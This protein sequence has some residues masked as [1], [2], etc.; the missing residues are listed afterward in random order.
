M[1]DEVNQPLAASKGVVLH[2]VRW[3]KDT[4][5]SFG[6]DAQALINDQ[7]ARMKEYAILVGIM[8][9]RL[10]TPT[11][12]AQS[13]TVEEFERAAEAFRQSGH[14][15][16]W[17][18]FRNAPS[19]FDTQEQLDQREGVLEFRRRLGNDGLTFAYK[20]PGDFR[21]LFRQHLNKWLINGFPSHDRELAETRPQPES[22]VYGRIELD[23]NF[24]VVGGMEALE[25]SLDEIL[26]DLQER[27]SPRVTVRLAPY[28]DAMR[29]LSG[30]EENGIWTHENRTLARR[31]RSVRRRYS[32][33]WG[34]PIAQFFR[35]A[36]VVGLRNLALYPDNFFSVKDIAEILSSLFQGYYSVFSSR[37]IEHLT[38]FDFFIPD[39]PWAFPIYLTSSELDALVK[40]QNVKSHWMLTAPWGLTFFDFSTQ[41]FHKKIMP[42]LL[43]EYFWCQHGNIP[44]APVENRFFRLFEWRSGLG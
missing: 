11:P 38:K 20:K 27:R 37:D 7:I 4:F 8:W 12:R 39:E 40:G 15:Q 18:Y 16:I 30:L 29:R 44:T 36:V 19:H 24:A 42:R 35:E 14:P 5:P 33:F 26:A 1:I 28:D 41:V 22:E 9:N 2:L 32:T 3:E 21:D 25:I 31:L 17:F 34:Q 13:G 43:I 6:S 10:G 23:K